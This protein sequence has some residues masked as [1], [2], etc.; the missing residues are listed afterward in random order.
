MAVN[1][2]P[3]D[4]PVLRDTIKVPHQ[5]GRTPISSIRVRVDFRDPAIVGD[6]V[7]HCHILGHEDKGMMGKIR[8]LPAETS[9]QPSPSTGAPGT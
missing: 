2:I 9:A 8:V 7:Y 3:V 1:G 5:Q 6:F 4:D